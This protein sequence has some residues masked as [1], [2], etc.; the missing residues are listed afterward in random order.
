MS[1]FGFETRDIDKSSSNKN[2]NQAGPADYFKDGGQKRDQSGYAPFG[3]LATKKKTIEKSDVGPGHY[4][5]KRDIINPSVSKYE[6]RNIIIVKV[7]DDGSHQFK[8]R[9]NRFYST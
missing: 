8:S 3:S 6:N 7:N 5:I 1:F 9:T 4:T 2:G